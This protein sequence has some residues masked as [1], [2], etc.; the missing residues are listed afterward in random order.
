M[1]V[2][3]FLSQLTPLT[4]LHIDHAFA[5]LLSASLL[6]PPLLYIV[7]PRYLKDCTV[8]KL[9]VSVSM[10]ICAVK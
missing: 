6:A 9:T 1:I 4:S 7:D 8:G 10:L 5:T 2:G 3:T